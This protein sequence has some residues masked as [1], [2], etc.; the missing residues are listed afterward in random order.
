MRDT[1]RARSGVSIQQVFEAS[2]DDR[3]KAED[4][5]IAYSLTDVLVTGSK[6][7]FKEFVDAVKDDKEPENALKKVL[8]TYSPAIRSK[9]SSTRT[10]AS[11]I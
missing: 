11:R 6:G 8:C 2:R 7:K 1:G 9:P 10:L 3:L 5:P 4:Y